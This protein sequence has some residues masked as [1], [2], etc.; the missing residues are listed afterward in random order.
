MWQAIGASVKGTSHERTGTP[1]QDFHNF[2]VTPKYVIVAAADGLG[3]APQS[4]AGAE[5][6]VRT[7]LSMI[8]DDIRLYQPLLDDAWERIVRE[9]FLAARNAIE[10]RSE[11]AEVPMRDFG[12]TL[13]V[14]IITQDRLVVGHLGDGAVVAQY[15]NGDV[16]TVTAPSHGEYANEVTPL[17]AVNGLESLEITIQTD[18][19]RAVAV[20]TDGLQ[21]LSINTMTQKPHAPF[22]APFFNGVTQGVIDTVATSAQ[23]ADF[24]ASE[25]VCKKTDDDKTLV[26]VGEFR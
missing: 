13:M 2:I 14:A 17:T 7:A 20:L 23:L 22:F 16:A 21:N 18:N 5:L 26:V 9:A 15:D 8:E 11:T 1:C 3:S 12:T 24:L 4:D 19:A 10:I 25:R 6:A